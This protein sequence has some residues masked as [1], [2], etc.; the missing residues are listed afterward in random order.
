MGGVLTSRARPGRSLRPPFAPGRGAPRLLRRSYSPALARRFPAVRAFPG[1][2]N[3]AGV[4]KGDGGGVRAA[5]GDGGWRP[6]VAREGGQ[7]RQEGG[8]A[9]DGAGR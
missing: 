7:R 3:A 2:Q 9:A 8:V 6:R 5:G 4:V 1:A